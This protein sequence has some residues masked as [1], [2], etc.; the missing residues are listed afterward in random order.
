[1]ATKTSTER[2]NAVAVSLHWLI[3]L[4]II[5]LIVVAK[6][7]HSLDEDDPLRFNLIQWH[8]SFGI[9]VLALVLLRI[10]WRLSHKPPALPQHMKVW[11]RLAA[12]TGHLGLYGLMLAMPLTGW[13]LVSASPLN[14]AT[15][16]FGLI[17]WPHLPWLENS[18]DKEVWEY[19]FSMSHYWLGNG[20][21][22]LV[23]VH[24]AAALRHQFFLRDGVLSRMTIARGDQNGGLVFGVVLLAAGA[25]ALL[26]LVDRQS[27]QASVGAT[28][29]STADDGTVSDGI[30]SDGAVTFSEV[31]FIASQLGD[32]V[33]G[34]F[35]DH[36]IRL[37]PTDVPPQ[38]ATLRAT[39]ETGS[40]STGDGQID[41]TVVTAEWFAAEAHPQATF[42]STSISSAAVGSYEV[43]GLLTIR[44]KA[45]EVTFPMQRQGAA[46]SGELTIDRRD[47][48]VGVDGQD[49][50]VAPEV[51]IFFRFN[52]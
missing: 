25:L 4:L 2:Y 33:E 46:F 51:T 27:G 13:A 14:L 35:T 6:I 36:E 37:E 40:V 10:V 12:S 52:L 29:P 41:A 3:A 50:F 43:S 30:A 32:P 38:Q 26:A 44:G 42:T 8:K 47:F 19:R 17:P 34:V 7:S 39:V 45:G 20:L 31:G 23:A 16:L 48:G 18:P 28:I 11:E 24:A 49:E 22:L 5:G 9:A 21:M 1:M 15:E